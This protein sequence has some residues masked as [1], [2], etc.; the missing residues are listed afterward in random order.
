MSDFDLVPLDYRL[1]L[2]QNN[3]L[4]M[5]SGLLGLLGVLLLLAYAMLTWLHNQ[6][7]SQLAELEAEQVI[8]Q[9]EIDA[10]QALRH[11]QSSL[12][13]QVEQLAQFQSTGTTQQLLHTVEEAAAD[14]NVW[15]THWRYTRQASS[16][17]H[18]AELHGDAVDHGALSDFVQQ[19]LR[20]PQ[21]VDA[22]ITRSTMKSD[23]RGTNASAN[24]RKIAFR[25]KLDIRNSADGPAS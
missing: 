24:F 11:Q 10:Y 3:L 5:F 4:Q 16:Q 17:P 23:S 22:G 20:S 8:K 12:K 19:L 6:S 1:Q 13:S 21:I 18:Q 15:L 2:A 7:Q 25:L 9:Q 14:G